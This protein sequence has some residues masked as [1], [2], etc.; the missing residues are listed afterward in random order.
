MLLS[1]YYAVNAVMFFHWGLGWVLHNP[2]LLSFLLFLV[3][4]PCLFLS[5][6]LVVVAPSWEVPVFL[7]VFLHSP[8]FSVLV[9]M[10]CVWCWWVVFGADE[11]CLV[12]MG[13]VCCLWSPVMS[14]ANVSSRLPEAPLHAC[15]GVG[16]IWK[17]GCR[18]YLYT[19]C[20]YCYFVVTNNR[21]WVL[22]TI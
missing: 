12:L 11:L 20:K 19:L 10:S 1:L 8:L 22:R 6:I 15:V 2:F 13:C 7:W 5:G 16:S 9:L 17:Y 14:V 18:T 21:N 3:F 4:Y